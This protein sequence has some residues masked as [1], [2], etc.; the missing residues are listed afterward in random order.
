[1]TQVTLSRPY[2]TIFLSCSGFLD[3]L[4]LIMALDLYP[5]DLFFYIATRKIKYLEINLNKEVKDLCSE[6]YTELRKEIKED[7][8]KWKHIPC[9]GLE[10]LTSSKCTTTLSNL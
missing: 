7:T 5:L 4:N 6:N 1:M 9:H 3:I 10:G 8:K 2:N